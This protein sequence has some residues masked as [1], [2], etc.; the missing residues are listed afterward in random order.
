MFF[1]FSSFS[2]IFYSL[3][4]VHGLHTE[5]AKNGKIVVVLIFAFEL[6]LPW[7]VIFSDLGAWWVYYGGESSDK[8]DV[9]ITTCLCMWWL[10]FTF[11]L[12]FKI[13]NWASHLF[14][15]QESRV[16]NFLEVWKEPPMAL[17]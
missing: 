9:Q 16:K 3:C 15:C 4:D 14:S 13:S 7:I 5:R 17:G 2:A 6:S 11:E 8:N 12:Y 10:N 1:I